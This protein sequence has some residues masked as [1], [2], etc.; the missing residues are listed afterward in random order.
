MTTSVTIRVT[1][2]HY[3]LVSW[4]ILWAGFLLAILVA[5]IQVHIENKW[6]QTRRQ[7]IE[8][9]DAAPSGDGEAVSSADQSRS[10]FRRLLLVALVTRAAMMPIHVWRDRLWVQFIADTLPQLAFASAWTLLVS[11]FVQLVG[12]AQGTATAASPGIL[13]IQVTACVVY[14][15]LVITF[16]FNIVAAV[17]MYAL[18][19]CM[20]SALFGTTM[21]FCPK[22]LTLLRPSLRQHSGLAIRLAACSILC[23]FVFGFST[24]G[25]ARKVVAPP[26][27]IL[28]WWQ[29]GFL[30]LIPSVLFLI[31]MRP[32]TNR[33]PGSGAAA[34]DSNTPSPP[35]TGGRRNGGGDTVPFVNKSSAGT[36]GYGSVSRT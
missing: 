9:G 24:F 21:Y 13:A 4:S 36:G 6:L 5:S 33:S 16:F 10:R 20:Y 7:D 14:V 2:A 17:L 19:C 22:L 1:P 12:V 35:I 32:N 25:F 8:Q 30:E 29:Y 34:T 23:L 28:W 11:F 3:Y 18:F 26:H 31:M 27:Q 15:A